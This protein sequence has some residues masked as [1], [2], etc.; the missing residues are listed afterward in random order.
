[1]KYP[2]TPHLPFSKVDADGIITTTRIFTYK[3]VII[4]EK[5]DGSNIAIK[6]NGKYYDLF[7]RSGKTGKGEFY[8]QLNQI[9]FT[10][11]PI[12]S[13]YIIYCEYVAYAHSIDYKEVPSLIFVISILDTK[14]NTFL[15]WDDTVKI[16]KYLGVPTVPFLYRGIIT[17]EKEL[18][19][20]CFSFKGKSTI[21]HYANK[22]GVVVRNSSSFKFEDFQLNV[23]KCV[24]DS[25]ERKNKLL[26][27]KLKV[28]KKYR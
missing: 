15:S 16:A 18:K 5:V 3:E 12:D 2:R 25:F 22:E 24:F 14:T 17:N 19:K 6:F 7:T 21:S 9:K 23:A 10:L 13:K 11:P 8:S 27:K 4:T 28:S 20:I 1:M 26:M